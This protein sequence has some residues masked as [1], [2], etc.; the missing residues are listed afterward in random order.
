MEVFD[1]PQ[2]TDEWL[3]LRAGIPTA[4]VIKDVSEKDGPRG[5][6]AR[7]RQTLLNKLAGEIL[8]GELMPHFTS[9]DTERGHEREEEASDLYAFLRDVEPKR[10]GFIRNGNCGGSPDR[11]IND[12]GILEI[13]DAAPHI[14]VERLL[15]GVVP[16]EHVPQCYGL[17]MISQRAWIDWMSHCR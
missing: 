15:A 14:Q 11:F 8:T 2:N 4:S 9:A 7:G 13:K 1:V 17:L 10:V 5:G 16:D 3:R 12:D 6:I